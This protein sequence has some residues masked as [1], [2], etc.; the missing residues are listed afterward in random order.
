MNNDYITSNSNILIG[1]KSKLF[2]DLLKIG[3]DNNE[4]YK[5]TNYTDFYSSIKS[6]NNN[7][8]IILI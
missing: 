2:I 3:L 7:S 8:K 1:S 6:L 4:T 5:I